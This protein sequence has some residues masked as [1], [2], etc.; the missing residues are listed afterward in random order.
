MARNNDCCFAPS[1]ENMRLDEA[2]AL[3]KCRL[4]PVTGVEKTPLRQAYGR[5]LASDVIALRDVPNFDNSAMDGYAVFFDDLDPD[6]ETRLQVK[7]R[8]KAGHSFDGKA[9]RGYAYRIFTGAPMPDGPD[10]VIMQEHCRIDGLAVIIKPGNKRFANLRRKGEDIATGSVILKKGI[11]LRPQEIALAASV[12]QAELEVRKR[13][14]VA[15]FSTGDEVRD[16]LLAASGGPIPGYCIYDANRY[17]AM[18]ML[19]GMGCEISDLGILPDVPDVIRSALARAAKDHDAIITSG[20]V[21]VGDEDH[22]KAAVNSLGSLHFW[23]LSIKPGRPVALGQAGSAAFIGLPGNPVSSMVTFM[24]IARPA[25][26]AL[27][28]REFADPPLFKVRASFSFAKAPGRMEWLRARLERD[29]NGE[30][31]AV[32]FR[33]EGSALLTSMVDADGLVEL[34][35][36]QAAV[37]KG[38]MVG[39]LPFSEV[40]F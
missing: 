8:I 32:K 25:L 33:S 37:A 16:P 40:S 11:R 24:R 29:E 13:L 7:G 10:A 23:R 6:G 17:A 34:A 14:K 2:L 18:G 19:E 3:L 27:S 26:L 20:G 38:D 12:G 35:E 39:F 4:K 9:E 1:G 22:V 5:V 21:S 36:D 28:G 31:T 30:L 15:V